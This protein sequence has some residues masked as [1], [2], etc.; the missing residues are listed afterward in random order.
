MECE[1]K[2]ALYSP[3]VVPLIAPVGTSCHPQRW[4][5]AVT[6]ESVL[7]KK[8]LGQDKLSMPCSMSQVDYMN[9]KAA[10]ETSHNFVAVLHLDRRV[11]DYYP[12]LDLANPK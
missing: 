8:T 4:T 6:P 9:L 11:L 1:A 2:P 5:A 7:Q 3:H 12:R 10:N